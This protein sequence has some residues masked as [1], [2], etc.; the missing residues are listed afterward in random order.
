MRIVIRF[1][2]QGEI[3]LPEHC[4]RHVQDF[5]YRAMG[6]VYGSF[7]HDIGFSDK[8]RTFRLFTFSDL[9]GNIRRRDMRWYCNTPFY[10]IVS[11][12]FEEIVHSLA[13]TLSANGKIEL[14]RQPVEVE[15]IHAEFDRQLRAEE[16][17]RMLAP[18]T[19]YSTLSS[20][21]GITKTYYYSPSEREFSQLLHDNLIRKYR[22]AYGVEPEPGC[23][24]IMPLGITRKHERIISYKG[25]HIKG[26][27]G[28]YRIKGNPELLTFAYHAGLGS[29]N[30]QGFGLFELLEPGEDHGTE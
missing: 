23:F 4:N 25:Q 28:K 5:V 30:A 29:K 18:V 24:S 8:K 11:S 10:L 7:V 19:M 22:A 27:L 12:P 21:T 26:W 3:S 17:I 13:N 6:P 1:N 2:V 14:G 15:S 9:F 20:P 16:T